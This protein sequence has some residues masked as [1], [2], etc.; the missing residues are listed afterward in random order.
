[1]NV[2]LNGDADRWLVS[3]GAS[4]ALAI[5]DPDGP[6][7]LGAGDYTSDARLRSCVA[8]RPKR[9]RRRDEET[10]GRYAERAPNCIHA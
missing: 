8:E 2:A 1:M 4:K 10:G 7:P 9:R 3:V 6:L 5:R